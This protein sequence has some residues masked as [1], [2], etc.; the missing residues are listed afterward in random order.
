MVDISG[1]D[2]VAWARE[3]FLQVGDVPPN[4][5]RAG[6]AESWRRSRLYA[7]DSAGLDPPFI[8]DL[9]TDGP[10]M[11][12]AQPVLDGLAE[13]LSELT[14]GLFVIDASG[15]VLHRRVV[16]RTLMRR[17][18]EIRLAPGFSYAEE[19]VGTNGIGTGLE[20]RRVSFVSGSEHFNEQLHA[21]A[22]A[23][24]PIR[25][26]LTGR[27]VGMLDITGWHKDVMPLMPALAHNAA[28]AIEQRLVELGSERERAIMAE[29][30]SIGRKAGRAAVTVGES[31]ILTNRLA[32]D[33]LAPA[34]HPIVHDRAADLLRSGELSGQVMLSRGEAATLR[35]HPIGTYTGTAVVEIDLIKVPRP[36]PRTVISPTEMGL[37]GSSAMFSKVCADL[38]ARCQ[39]GVWTLVEGEP[40]VGKVTLAEAAHRACD[41]EGPLV[42]IEP[43]DG[44]EDATARLDQVS[45]S[46]SARRSVVLRHPERFT[47]AALTAITAWM[48]SHPGHQDRP[49]LVAT[50]SVDAELPEGLLR[51]LPVTLTVPPLRHRIDDVRE[52]VPDLLRRLNADPSVSCGPA[53]MRILLRSSWPGNVAELAQVLR[54]ALTRTRAGQIRPEHLPAACHTVSRHVLTPWETM[55]RDAIVQA[56]L[57]TNGDKTEA[58]DLLGISRAT[59]YRKIN[60]YGVLVAPR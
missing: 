52:L 8:G 59:I 54:H 32:V 33:L 3:R 16:D 46:G 40:G 60:T 19:H 4:R 27:L 45:S 24:A 57:E 15:R 12:A 47:P 26:Q 43:A 10:L 14:V 49:W 21:M 38:M 56:L 1:A 28:S 34:D 23:G 13:T 31:L 39:A 18:D 25:D 7:V 5:L 51:S 35:C 55:E 48:D 41:R 17:L 29:F 44:A 30:L 22:C 6:I 36:A 20:T 58:A 2:S 53:A 42:M 11:R 9:D 37:A 50:A